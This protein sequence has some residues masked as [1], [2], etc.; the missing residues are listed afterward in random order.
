TYNDQRG[1]GQFA[2]V[3][4]L[5]I[6]PA[7]ASEGWIKPLRRFSASLVQTYAQHVDRARTRPNVRKIKL[8]EQLAGAPLGPPQRA[9]GFKNSLAVGAGRG[10]VRRRGAHCGRA[11][12]DWTDLRR[13]I[14]PRHRQQLY[15]KAPAGS[16]AALVACSWG[17]H[18]RHSD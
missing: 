16:G 8:L 10:H 12:S 5:C 1:D 14:N 9:S 4:A 18:S 6:E 3:G 2:S 15:Y 17:I 11:A 13:E 7:K